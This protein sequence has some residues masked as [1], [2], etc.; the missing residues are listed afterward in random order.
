MHYNDK[1]YNYISLRTHYLTQINITMMKIG[2]PLHEII[3]FVCLPIAHWLNLP[4][5]VA[6]SQRPFLSPHINNLSYSPLFQP[7]IGVSRSL[8]FL[9]G[10]FSK[11]RREV[12]RIN[13]QLSKH[14][15][16]ILPSH[17]ITQQTKVPATDT[18]VPTGQTPLPLNEGVEPAPS[19]DFS[20]PLTPSCTC[21]VSSQ[22]PAL[23][24]H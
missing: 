14:L 5:S 2:K 1:R 13:A 4:Q 21:G 20:E 7:L 16:S 6:P 18:A 8:T 9:V 15:A 12:R 23:P 24:Y 19:I 3:L 10:S 11:L 17:T 22:I